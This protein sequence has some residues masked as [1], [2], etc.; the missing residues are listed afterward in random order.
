MPE[1]ME[2]EVRAFTDDAILLKE[3]PNTWIPKSVI[4]DCDQDL[5]SVEKGDYIYFEM[6]SWFYKQE[7]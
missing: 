1:P 4:E 3:Y 7:F 6:A 5:D 2:G